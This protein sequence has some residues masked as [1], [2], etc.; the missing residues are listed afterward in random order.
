MRDRADRGDAAIRLRMSGHDDVFTAA[1]DLVADVLHA[2][3]RASL[4]APF[5]VAA[6]LERAVMT[7]QGDFEDVE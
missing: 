5:D 2:L 4:T 1:S 7:Y 3:N 6:F